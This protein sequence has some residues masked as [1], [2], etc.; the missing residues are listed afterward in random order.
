MSAHNDN[1][2]G[3]LTDNLVEDN[4]LCSPVNYPKM[5]PLMRSK[6]KLHCHKVPFV[7]TYHVPYKHKYPEQYAHHLLFLFYPFQ[8][9]S[10]LL[11]KCDRTYT[12]ELIEQHALE[13]VNRNKLII[14]PHGDIVD[15]AFSSYKTNHPHNVDSFAQQENG[16]TNEKLQ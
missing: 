12:S 7:L 4:S 15:S 8:D 10:A 3:E 13:I 16:L 9:E 2:P 14:E 1:Q 5:L 11:S 6:E